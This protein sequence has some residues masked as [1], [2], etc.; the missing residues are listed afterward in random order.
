MRDDRAPRV[1]R[2]HRR[3]REALRRAHREDRDRSQRSATPTRSRCSRSSSKNHPNH[4]QFTPDA[5]FRLADLYLDQADEEVEARLA[6]QEAAPH[7]RDARSAAIVADYSKSIASVEDI[8]KRVPELPP[9]AVDAL[10]ARVLRQDQ[11]RAPVAAAVPRA[12]VREPLQVERSAAAA[13]DAGRRR[14]SASRARRCAIRTPTA[15]PLSGRRRRARAPRV[16]ARHRRLPLHRARR[17]RRGDR[18]VP[19]GRQRRQ[20]LASSTPSRSTSS[21]GATTSATSCS[22]R[23]SAS[24]RA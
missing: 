23:S 21:R 2:A 20:G 24:T 3:A 15:Q 22:T 6:A 4:E 16:G 11:G 9:D 8:L 13:A 18:R 10:P 5:M 19:Q 7:V 14:S 12:R 17:A 1:R